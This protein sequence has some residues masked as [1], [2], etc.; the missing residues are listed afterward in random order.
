MA[1]DDLN[2]LKA[3]AINRIQ[4][5]VDD[6]KAVL[7]KGN[8]DAYNEERVKIA[9]VVPL[10]EAL[11]WNPRTDSILPEQA[12]LTGRADFGLRINGRTKVFVEMKSFSK[13]LD[14][15]DVV[16][17]RP[18]L[19]SEQAIQYAWGMKADWAT[20]T[21]FEE[22]RLYDS[23]VKKPAEGLV[24][25][26]PLKFTEYVSRFDELWLLSRHSVSSGM[27][28]S[29]KAKARRPPVTEAFLDDLANCRQLLARN[30]KERNPALSDEQLNESVQKILDRL[31]FI[32]N[33]EDRLIIPAESLWK[34]FKAW[35]E[36]AI[37]VNVVTFMM[38]LKNLFRYFDQVYNGKL[39]EKHVCED[40]RISNNAL[41]QV[42][43]I[44]YGDN[45]HLGYNFSVIPV[46]ILGQAYEVY[47]GSIIKEK[48]G[49]A[50][51]LEIIK[52]P[53]KRKE[54]G[55]YYTPEAVVNFI[56][57]NTVGKFLEGCNEPK[58]V[59]TI[60][61]ID[62]ACGSG[63]FLI[64]NVDV[65]RDWHKTF[66]DRNRSSALS[67]KL[68]AHLPQNNVEEA[69]L[70]ENLF[71]VDLDPQAVEITILNLSLKAVA[72]K[73]RLPYMG[74][75][76]KC[77]NSIVSSSSLNW[78]G[79]FTHPD[80]M[81]PFDWNK[82]FGEI[83]GKG[84]F[85]VVVGNPPYVTMEKLP[86]YQDYC[87]AY[88]PEVYSGKNDFH[89][90]FLTKGVQLLRDKGLLGFITSRYYIEAKYARKLRKYILENSC[91]KAIIDFGNFQVFDGV[92]V[93]TSI[94][95]LQ[96]NASAAERQSNK[97]KIIAVKQ[98]TTNIADLMVNIETHMNEENF[99]DDQI[100]CF[101]IKQ[102]E[103]SEDSWELDDEQ[104][105]QIKS[106]M[107]SNSFM[108]KD[109]CEIEQSQKSGLNEA[110]VVSSAY[111]K[112]KHLEEELLRKVI[113]NSDVL[114]YYIDWKHNL[115]I[116]TTD[117]TKIEDYPNTKKHLEKYKAK[118]ESRAKEEKG[119]Y[120]WYR[121][122][123]P[124]RENLYDAPEKIM[125]PYL[126][127]ENRFALD[128]NKF[129]GL[130]DTYAIVPKKDCPLNLKYIV[131][132]LNSKLL[133]F[134]HKRT[135]K[136]K[137]GE[138][139]EY[140]AK[141]LSN[142]P[143]KK[144][145]LTNDLSR[146]R[147]N[148]LINLAEN[149]ATLKKEYYHTLHLFNRMLRNVQT[150]KTEICSFLEDYYSLGS[151]YGM[152]LQLSE[153]L[154]DDSII[155]EVTNI[156]VEEENDSLVFSAK[157]IVNDGE[158]ENEVSKRLV[159]ICFESESLRQFFYYCTKVFLMKNYKK[160]NWGKGPVIEVVLGAIKIPK[161][162]TNVKI[163]KEEISNLMK[164]FNRVSPCNFSLSMVELELSETEENVNSI[165]VELYGLDKE[166]NDYVNSHIAQQRNL[167]SKTI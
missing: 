113:K 17:G 104:T 81:R 75:H 101:T 39:F 15:H 61:I 92:N 156:S 29:F 119:S 65:I 91:I 55:I 70:T 67:G 68:D 110:F 49:L 102:S 28:D 82:E 153:K 130:A 120:A 132:L 26:K 154:V 42:I 83:I 45:Q 53:K 124:R 64:K 34:R 21:N 121:L 2:A 114:K 164:E 40:L 60:K 14:G 33:C 6:Y 52:E 86:E 24:W 78:Q 37:D 152:N 36:T 56:V 1:N 58:D 4:S 165:I 138:Y 149:I 50:S 158:K 25:K 3:Q 161:F 118:L 150:S 93:L 115:L 112:E 103:F 84:G 16:K 151:Q 107:R 73:K 89:Y 105:K 63:S 99:S 87:K 163:N 38:D 160:R 122:Q 47:I 18:R 69:I 96:K 72:P 157:Y 100:S 123:R 94:I 74:D 117:E 144:I 32:K 30:I 128:N 35:Q 125:V 155:G 66:N 22:T 133:E 43:N 77:G 141:P 8:K 20:L 131:A 145:D 109:V 143:I 19:Y 134:Y 13:S 162:V 127:T 57:Q 129:Y 90:Y 159:K 5:L 76:V 79:C 116:Y 136:L 23:H 48:Q 97:I 85:D 27:L 80:E 71:G 95:I 139:Y 166:Q 7:A 135:A 137:R 9:F 59:S 147:Y 111:A 44:L 88:Y 142:L 51:A 41:E 106:Q 31:I 148:K 108:L 54:Y 10:L 140:F 98:S 62:P 46:D 12:T 146:D 11:G 167:V 126:S